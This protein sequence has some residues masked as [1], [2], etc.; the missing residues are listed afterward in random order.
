MMTLPLIHLLQQPGHRGG[1]IVRDIIARRAVAEG[2]WQ[3]ILQLLAEHRSIDY[4]SRRAVEFAERAKKQ[5]SAFPPSSERDAL[6]ALPDY[7]L[8]RDR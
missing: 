5:L 6:I 1:E 3:E 4:A 2:Q 8:S 7:V